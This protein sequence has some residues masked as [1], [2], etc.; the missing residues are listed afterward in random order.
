M[1]ATYT[2]YFEVRSKF[3]IHFETLFLDQAQAFVRQYFET[4]KDG[5]ILDIVE[6]TKG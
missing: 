6:V 2:K 1:E 5:T 4:S 3:R